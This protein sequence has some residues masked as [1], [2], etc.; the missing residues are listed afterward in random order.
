VMTW[1]NGL[2]TYPVL[3]TGLYLWDALLWSVGEEKDG[4]KY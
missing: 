1:R 2:A 4:S 3:K